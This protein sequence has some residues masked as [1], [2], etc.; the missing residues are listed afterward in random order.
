MKEIRLL[1]KEYITNLQYKLKE[2]EIAIQIPDEKVFTLPIKIIV[3]G[4]NK[5]LR[6]TVDYFFTIA[7]KKE[8]FNGRIIHISIDNKESKKLNEQDCLF[9]L[10]SKGLRNSEIEDRW[11]LIYSV[12]RIISSDNWSEILKKVVAPE[13]EFLICQPQAD[14]IIY[15]P[16]DSIKKKPPKSYIGKII[17][18]LYERYR[19]YRSKENKLTIISLDPII[20]KD[21]DLKG[22]ILKA[23]KEWNLGER[24]LS[25]VRLKNIFFNSMI[26]KLDIGSLTEKEKKQYFQQLQYRD[27]FITLTENYNR[28]I[29]SEVDSSKEDFPLVDVGLD[30]EFTKNLDTFYSLDTW[31]N[32]ILVAFIPLAYLSGYNKTND[33]LQDILIQDFFKKFLFD[34]IKRFVDLSEEKIR[35]WEEITINRLKNPFIKRTL[36]DMSKN[37]IEKFRNDFLFKMIDLYEKNQEIPDYIFFILA[38]FLR[39]FNVFEEEDKFFGIREITEDEEEVI[40]D[41]NIDDSELEKNKEIYEVEDDPEILKELSETWKDV[42]INDKSIDIFLRYILTQKNIWG[43]DLTLWPN[44]MERTSHYLKK[45]LSEDM[46]K[47][48]TELLLNIDEI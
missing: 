20:K 33:A 25:W 24:F 16:D 29:I 2:R 1:N 26:D 44:L 7:L 18:I 34:T 35:K 45:I 17:S 11:D 31:F 28:W 36:I 9:T 6:S 38:V 39:F 27:Y 48:T 19:R 23:G 30:F 12:K 42:Q 3:L 8:K 14:S 46:A 10:N 13:I 4:H 47:V 41:E 32:A 21:L 15:D 40:V 43:M 37:L 22:M 5:F